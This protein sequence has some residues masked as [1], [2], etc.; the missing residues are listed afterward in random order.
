MAATFAIRLL[1]SYLF[2][3]AVVAIFAA[4]GGVLNYISGYHRPF[5][6]T[7]AAIAYPNKPDIVSIPVVFVVALLAPAGIIAVVNFGGLAFKSNPNRTGKDGWRKV[8][9]EV[10][11]GWLGLCAALATTLFVTAGLKDM[12]GKPRPNLLARCAP[13]LSSI[14][15]YIVGGFGN[16]LNSEAESLVSSGICRQSDKRLL[17]DGFAAFPSGHSSF[18]S[19][20]MVYLSLWL[21]ARF[22]SGIP[23]PDITPQRGLRESDSWGTV[24]WAKQKQAAP[25]LWRIA[26]TLAPIFAALF[27]CA[28]RYADFHHAGFD[29]ISGA[30]IGTVIGWA[31]FRLYHLPARRGYGPFPWRS[32]EK[33]KGHGIPE[34]EPPQDEE[35][36]PNS[37]YELRYLPAAAPERVYT[38]GSGEPILAPP[39]TEPPKTR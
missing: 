20:G 1:F 9:W 24:A 29:I 26:V 15:Q 11:V 17:D 21:Y 6:L 25:S 19:A 8:V 37:D 18:S 31:S 39:N 10:H 22:S 35:R 27:I 30:V 2:D 5:S 38:G 36:G 7:D 34:N 13:D 23:S 32:R 4:A 3:W 12:V 28:S 33:L 14:S 16:S